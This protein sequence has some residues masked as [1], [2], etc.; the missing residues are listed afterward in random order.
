MTPAVQCQ[1]RREG[2]ELFYD[3]S[4]VALFEAIFGPGAGDMARAAR[5]EL[6]LGGD[7]LRQYEDHEAPPAHGH[8][9]FVMHSPAGWLDPATVVHEFAHYW[10]ASRWPR[11]SLDAMPHQT[12]AVA[13]AA[14]VKLAGLEEGLGQQVLHR[15]L[16]MHNPHAVRLVSQAARAGATFPEC[17]RDLLTGRYG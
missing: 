15:V 5:V 17:A 13:L 7:R 11:E 14:E 3:A 16:A 6:T 1:A 4:R 10:H 12:E 2:D 8:R 9:L